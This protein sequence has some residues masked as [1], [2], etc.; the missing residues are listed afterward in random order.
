MMV[1][2]AIVA[3]LGT[4]V[5]GGFRQNE[6]RGA[7]ARFIEDLHG[8]LVTARHIAIDDQ[9]RVR[10]RFEA[11]GLQVQRFDAATEQWNFVRL[12][13]RDQGR[14]RGPQTTGD[15]ACVLAV[16]AGISTPSEARNA[17]P[18]DTCLTGSVTLTFEPDGRFQTNVPNVDNTGVTLWVGDRRMVDQ[19]EF[20]VI[21]VFPGGY[22]RVFNDVGVQS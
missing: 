15:E 13:E 10:V 17:A 11:A 9:T 22:I 6:A 8:A 1:A 18:P 14:G 21:Q 3:I 12:A 19:P 20:S 16:Q 4:L 2:L 5:F 7:Y